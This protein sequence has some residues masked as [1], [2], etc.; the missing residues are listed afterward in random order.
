MSHGYILY[1]VLIFSNLVAPPKT[2]LHP[3]EFGWNSVDSVLLP[4]MYYYTTRDVQLLVATR[5]NAPQDVSAAS[6]ALHAQNFAS[7]LEKNGAPK[8]TIRISWTLHKICKYK[9]FLLATFSNIWTES[10]HIYSYILPRL[11]YF[12]D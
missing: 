8:F 11:T 1:F 5:K 9:D 7:A 3:V 10:K 12:T 4:N 2:N 6:L